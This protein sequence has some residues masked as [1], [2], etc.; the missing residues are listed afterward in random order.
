VAKTAHYSES[1]A[2]AADIMMARSVLIVWAWEITLTHY[3][4]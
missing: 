3:D 2:I 1:M 4:V